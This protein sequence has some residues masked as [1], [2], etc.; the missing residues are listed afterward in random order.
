MI[1]T[2]FCRPNLT[3]VDD[4]VNAYPEIDNTVATMAKRGQWRVPGY[5]ERFGEFCI[6]F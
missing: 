4:V 2:I 3:Q 6:G 1:V 5:Y